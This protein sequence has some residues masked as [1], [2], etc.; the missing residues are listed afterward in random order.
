MAATLKRPKPYRGRFLLAYAA[1][2]ASVGAGIGGLVVVLTGSHPAKHV[3]PAARAH[4]WSVW[5]PT[6][7]APEARAREIAEHVARTYR[8]PNGDQLLDVTARPPIIPTGT[9]TKPVPISYVIVKGVRGK[10]DEQTAIK[11][12][13]SELYNLCGLGNQ[14]LIPIGKPSPERLRLIRRESLELALYTFKYVDGV[15]Y[16]ITVLPP[17]RGVST[18]AALYFH[19]KDL[20]PQLRRPLARTLMVRPRISRI[21]PR[22]DALIDRLTKPHMFRLTLVGSQQGYAILGL[23]PLSS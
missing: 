23:T 6:S 20:D 19:R 15:K 13:N 14:C 17:I 5:A 3:V 7:S 8:L 11:P 21:A 9:N 10:R 12:K 16:V 18:A 1:L 4:P 2:A 22:E